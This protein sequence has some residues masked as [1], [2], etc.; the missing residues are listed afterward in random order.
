M[1]MLDVLLKKRNGQALTQEEVNFFVEGYVQGDIPDYQA[2]ALLMAIYFQGL[3]EG[4]TAW[5]TQAMAASGD[6][7]DLSAI[8]GIKVD[9]HS[10]GGVGDKTTLIL[11]PLVAA[12]GVPVAKMSGKGLGHT[13]GTIDKLESIP[14]FQT[15]L[16][17]EAFIAQV[18]KVGLSVIG[19]SGNIAP[20]DKMLYALRDVTGTVDQM[21]LIAASI[22]SKKMAAGADAI[23][24]DVKTGSGAFMK[25]LEDS[26]ALAK[27]MVSIG[28][29]VGRKT[30]ALI[31]D[32]DRPLGHAIGNALEVREAVATLK[33]HGPEDL[34]HLCLELAAQ[35]LFVAQRGDLED[36]RQ[37][38]KEALDS[39]RAMKKLEEMVQ[40]QG[41]NPAA[42]HD[43]EALA[44]SREKAH[45]S[46][47]KKGFIGAIDTQGCGMAS[48]LL[49]AGRSRK[50]D[51]IDYGAGI[52][53]HKSL[54]EEVE[55]GEVIA[56]LYAAEEDLLL[57]GLDKL[58]ESITL[59]DHAPEVPP[60]IQA[61]ISAAGVERLI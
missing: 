29:N 8:A 17:Q 20:A 30:V 13:G 5:L 42:L 4:E 58:K 10:T 9:K 3:N 46:A 43:P 24:L 27:E 39:G 50:E 53:L 36:C 23:V 54:G 14:G 12:C 52:I 48:V 26:V 18:Q 7:V 37:Q 60:L 21:G 2:S 11:G 38:V 56:T 47:W 16:S 59:V 61:R 41:G 57:Q 55:E 34:I 49:G 33:G 15:T 6:Q 31:T 51:A 45:V 32:M 44:P 1:R 28:E 40:A 35:M 22:M 25:T 19:Q